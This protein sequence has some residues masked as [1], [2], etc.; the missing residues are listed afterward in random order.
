MKI[1]SKL[2]FFLFLFFHFSMNG[3]NAMDT[4]ISDT[5]TT[6]TLIINDTLKPSVTKK[7][8]P[9]N[10]RLFIGMDIGRL[11]YNFYNLNNQSYDFQLCYNHNAKNYWTIESGFGRGKVDLDFLKY[12]ADA[13]YLKFGMDRSLIDIRNERDFDIAFMGFRY[14]AAFGNRG[15][16]TYSIVSPFGNDVTGS[17]DAKTFFKH[18]GE[19]T[20]GMRLE[21]QK[22]I[23]IGWVGRA[24]F[25]FNGNA[26]T[27]LTPSFIPGYG[28]G[29]K[30][31][32]FDIGL[33]LSYA[34]SE[35]KK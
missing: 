3:Q 10:H 8:I 16:A 13:M 32:V 11:A 6:S 9:I 25:A 34:I 15:A 20:A 18:W 33:L 23:H 27:E 4:T 35:W 21:V 14:G 2:I 29:D 22:R 7:I 28:S 5:A 12:N 19:I 31:T 1:Q 17:I 26:T 30:T 24:K